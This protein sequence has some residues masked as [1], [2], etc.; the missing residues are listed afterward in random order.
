[1]LREAAASYRQAVRLRPDLV[2][3]HENLGN[4]LQ[5]LARPEEALAC[6]HEA[7]RYRPGRAA[8]HRNLGV[9]LAD[10]GRLAEAQ[11]SFERAI[12]LDP[13]DAEAHLNHALARLLQG[14]YEHGLAEAEWGKRLPDAVAR[15]F[16]QP[17]WDGAP[18]CGRAIL[19]YAEQGLGDT[20]HFV[21]YTP[22]VKRRGGTVIV[23][24]PAALLS[25]LSACPGIDRLLAA[26]APLP[27]FDVQTSLP[28]LPWIVGTT[29]ATVP[30]DIPYLG[31]EA[32]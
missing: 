15:P 12:Q 8:A 2:E 13:H 10:L 16:A 21:R 22:L 6:Y 28:S 23:E 5:E 27:P 3:A 30:A 29:V 14:D 4:V 31:V 25:V 32:P 18:L 7:L 26:G 24:C 20:L 11:A 19:L 17:L 9:A 1:N